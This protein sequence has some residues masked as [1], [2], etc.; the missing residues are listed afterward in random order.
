MCTAVPEGV[1]LVVPH[2]AGVGVGPF[3]GAEP[4][5]VALPA[6]PSV[7]VRAPDGTVWARSPRAARA[8]T[9]IA[10]RRRR[11]GAVGGRRCR[12]VVGRGARRTRSA[13]VIIDRQQAEGDEAYGAV[14][15]EYA[16]GEQVDVKDRRCPGVRRRERRRSASAGWSKA[17]RPTSPRRSSTTGS[18][19]TRSTT[20]TRRRI[21]AVQR[22]AAVPVADRRTCRRRR[23]RGAELG[24]GSR[25]ERRD[26]R[27]RGRL[28]AG[29]RRCRERRRV[30]RL[31]L[32]DARRDAGPRRL[33]RP[34]LGRFVRAWRRVGRR[35]DGRATSGG[36]CR[37]PGRHDRQ[38]STVSVRRR[39]RFRRRSLWCRR[40]RRRR[41]HRRPRRLAAAAHHGGPVCPTYEPNDR[42][43]IRLCDEGPA[44]RA[45]QQALVAA[46]HDV[47]VDGYFGPATERGGAPLPGGPRP[48]GR[49]PRRRR[50][51][52]RVDAVRPARRRRHG[53]QRC[54]RPMGA[55]DNPVAPPPPAASGSS[56]G[57]SV[58]TGWCAAWKGRR[59]RAIEYVDSWGI[60]G[61]GAGL[62]DEQG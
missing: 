22:P 40:R 26:E 37:L 17:R 48:R 50:H 23:F 44:V 6:P 11:G 33:R 47:D 24:R 5:G 32:G 29:R 61:D 51:V 10:C 53:R 46:G 31:D 20:G 57:R 25:L 55:R 13:A 45:I 18:T 3:D 15:V 54:D 19:A 62:G 59:S 12:A 34:L 38:R 9:C 16:D 27:H 7:A 21:G 39:H 49:R 41:P 28:V 4:L 42:Y 60:A 43:P 8:P 56:S 2:D 1:T 35:H 52:A 36:R 14:I 58:P 30:V